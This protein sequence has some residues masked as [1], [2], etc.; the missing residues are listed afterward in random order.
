MDLSECQQ[1]QQ[2]EWEVL[3][4]IYPDCVSSQICNGS[5]KLEIPV[6]FG[7][8]RNVAI[9]HNGS[10]ELL[11]LAML[12]PLLLDIVLPDSYPRDPPRIASL[13]ATH[14]WL[15]Y[16]IKLEEE[17]LNMFQAGEGV[18]Y[19]WVD[20]IRTGQFLESLGMIIDSTTI[21]ISH[22]APHILSPQLM[23]YDSD[24]ANTRFA[25]NSYSCAICLA[26]HKGS[27]CIQLTC[28]HIFCRS[29][30]QDFW[31]MCVTE[32][33]IVRVVCPDPA[34]VKEARP[35]SED[36]VARVLSTEEVDRWRWLKDKYTLEKD[37]S[38]M[39]C[40]M[41]P[42]DAESGWE[43]LRTCPSCSFSFCSFCKHT[44]HGP[45][46]P[47]L[48]ATDEIVKEY[49]ALPKDSPE[50]ENM[51]RRFGRKT[52]LKLV[53]AY[54]DEQLNRKFLESSTTPC[55]GCQVYVEK[56]MGCNHMTCSKCKQHFCYRCGEKLYGN[57]Y[58][59]FSTRNLPCYNKLF[60]FN[61]M[62]D[63]DGFTHWTTY[64]YG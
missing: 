36:E 60:D 64:D 39:H 5:L 50:R 15:P 58:E 26:H 2:E 51:Y 44:W 61:S 10:T 52:V 37:P 49:L 35:A 46:S 20:F 33:A 3:E 32:G 62:D 4:S 53:A 1:L 13:R 38:I 54:E 16:T 7:E 59:H 17:L 22:P 27:K 34:C 55:P 23:T 9:S 14:F 43:R 30:L 56:S 12:P 11:T 8:P 41:N 21:S 45:I 42:S 31:Q 19:T 24:Y 47:C 28:Q 63:D 18:L 25:Q 6:E 48:A 57:P 40:P 29:C